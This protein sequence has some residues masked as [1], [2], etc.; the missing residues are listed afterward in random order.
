MPPAAEKG[1]AT[2]HNLIYAAGLQAAARSN[3]LTGRKYMADEYLKRAKDI[4]QQV[5]NLCWDD[6]T[7]LYKEGPKVSR[8]SQHDQV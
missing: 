6:E 3:E 7:G 4:L 2:V 8:Y 5:E 1:P